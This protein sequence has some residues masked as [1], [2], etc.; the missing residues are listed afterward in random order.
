MFAS[1]AK[2]S[3]GID[4]SLHINKTFTDLDISTVMLDSSRL[5]Q[6]LINLMTNAIKFTKSS[7]RKNIDVFLDAYVDAPSK[8]EFDYFPNRGSTAD[9][10]GHEEWGTGQPLFLHFSVKDTGCGITAEEKKKLFNRFQQASPR[11]HIQYGGSG[12]GLFISRY[13]CDIPEYK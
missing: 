7:S 13:S 4:L 11:T 1:E 9:L 5:L 2:K 12:L 3:H 10:T 8:P 6:I